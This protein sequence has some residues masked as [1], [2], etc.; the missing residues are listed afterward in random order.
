MTPLVLILARTQINIT[1]GN[2]ILF[3]SRINYTLSRKVKKAEGS[4]SD[5]GHGV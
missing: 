3:A 5:D 4:E 2:T 1:T